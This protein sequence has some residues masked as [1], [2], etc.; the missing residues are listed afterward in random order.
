[1]VPVRSNVDTNDSRHLSEVV[2]YHST[3]NRPTLLLGIA[4]LVSLASA[5]AKGPVVPVVAVGKVGSGLSSYAGDV[6]Q[7]AT[8]C[9]YKRA[10]DDPHAKDKT[11]FAAACQDVSKSDLL[12]QRSMTVLAAYGD[13]VAEIASGS[14]PETTGRLEAALSGVEGEN[15]V[16]VGG[17]EKAARDAVT[18]LV[19][20][21]GGRNDK[22][23]L[24]EAVSAAAPHVKTVC[25]GL[26]AFLERQKRDAS[27]LHKQ[28]EEK[29]TSP[30]TRR[31]AMLDGRSVCVSDSAIDSLG[32]AET[33]SHVALLEARH[34]QAQRSVKA[35]CA[36]HAKLAEAAEAGNL[37]DEKT[38][39]SI[40]DAVRTAK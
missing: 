8:L 33:L 30:T 31:C 13:N 28:I 39:Q 32:Y 18:K 25:T 35:F 11:P 23:D 27:D 9:A 26:D 29:R 37:K 34:E 6:P 10:L 1:M 7:G 36:A 4:A 22:T 2:A 5:C 16:E 12:W 21:L 24:K 38:Y 14:E 3:M 40:V 19:E 15:W 17:D 20:Q